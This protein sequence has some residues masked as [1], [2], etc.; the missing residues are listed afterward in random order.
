[1]RA[2]EEFLAPRGA[3]DNVSLDQVEDE[4]RQRLSRELRTRAARTA[5]P[6]LQTPL[7]LRA[8]ALTAAAAMV[9]AFLWWRP[10]ESA[11]TPAVRSMAP[12]PSAKLALDQSSSWN[13]SRL[14][15]AWNSIEGA[16]RYLVIVYDAKLKE[17]DSQE[18]SGQQRCEFILPAAGGARSLWVRV[19]AL[20]G[21][22][23]LE[24]TG[25]QLVSGVRN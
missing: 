9:L 3:A 21:A 14:Q 7:R 10:F 24:D 20:R 22:V 25:L 15:L 18:V 2:L 17:L 11:E 8:F 19:R 16:E 1:L 23:Q 5:R 4:L 12:S 13:G 6:R